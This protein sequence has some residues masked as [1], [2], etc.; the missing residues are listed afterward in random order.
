MSNTCIN[1]SIYIDALKF[2]YAASQ[3]H[4]EILG[5][6]HENDVLS[7]SKT[8]QM[9]FSIPLEAPEHVN[10]SICLVF[11]VLIAILCLNRERIK[12]LHENNHTCMDIELEI[13]A[14]KSV[15][16]ISTCCC[17]SCDDQFYMIIILYAN[18]WVLMINYSTYMQHCYFMQI[19]FLQS[20]L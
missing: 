15:S 12:L 17:D 19:I 3:S 6:F 9:E 7:D 5:L 11:I 4:M 14:L 16:N 20:Y 8:K 18:V 1:T 2:D 10:M 13:D